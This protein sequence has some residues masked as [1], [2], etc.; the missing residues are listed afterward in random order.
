MALTRVAAAEW[1]GRGV[2]VN[3]VGPGFTETPLLRAAMD[4]G[5]VDQ[6]RVQQ[7]TPAGR[8]GRPDEIAA[9]VS[10]LASDD[11]SYVNGQ[12]VFVDGGFLV[13]YGVDVRWTSPKQQS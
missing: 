7:R 11:A 4:S 10:F 13:D 12:T 5:L 8:L 3:A 2:R 1:A 9:V 6:L